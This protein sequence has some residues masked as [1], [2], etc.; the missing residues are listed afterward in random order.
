LGQAVLDAL[1]DRVAVI[2]ADGVVMAVN[3]LWR[4]IGLGPEAE[5]YNIDIGAHFTTRMR[6]QPGGLDDPYTAGCSVVADGVEAVL[7]GDLEEFQVSVPSPMPDHWDTVRV[8]AMSGAGVLYTARDV[9]AQVAAEARRWHDTTHDP[10]TG[11]PNRAL[12]MQRLERLSAG[13]PPPALG[14][15]RIDLD[16][17]GRVGASLG[18]QAADVTLS[19]LAA[20]LRGLLHPGEDL[21]RIG[22]AS[23]VA[24][25]E[26]TSGSA[27]VELA[28]RLSAAVNAPLQCAGVPVRLT[29]SVGVAVAAGDHPTAD[30]LMRDASLAASQARAD[31]RGRVSVARREQHRENLE[32]LAIEQALHGALERHELRLEFQPEV[33]LR[34]GRV[35]GA[36]ALLR[37]DHPT[38]GR[39]GPGTFV[40][41]AEDLGLIEAIGHW[42]LSEACRQAAQWRLP[43]DLAEEL[44]V[45]V[46]LSPYQLVDHAF[47]LTVLGVLLDAGLPARRLCVEVT[48]G[49]LVRDLD[50]AS[51]ILHRL[52][53]LGV[54][55][56]IDD[57]GTGY[58]SFNYLSRLPLDIVKL[59]RSLVMRLQHEPDVALVESVVLLARRLGLLVVAEGVEDDTQHAL[60]EQLGC[61]IVQG[62]SSGPPG[63]EAHLLDAIWTRAGA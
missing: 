41:V 49:A 30:E 57:F 6:T 8:V 35:V 52:R 34:T 5:Q 29:A 22:D 59:D 43:D 36:E 24:V 47:P 55:V 38:L 58:S 13:P 16:G 7:R 17:F 19:E 48:E 56:A 10:V 53:E 2:G 54:R 63:D 37:W 44:Y 15:V 1:D 11:L 23:F 4:A 18:S 21:A 26:A 14:V 9:S 33:S 45:A 12:L 61:H 3:D 51:S 39:I 50:L 32:R 42:V 28:E 31:G 25:A 46:N 60:L 40:G 62:Y 20:R 27:V